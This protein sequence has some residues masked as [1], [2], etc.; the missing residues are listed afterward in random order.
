MGLIYYINLYQIYR[1]IEIEIII[2]YIYFIIMDAIEITIKINNKDY[3]VLSTF[4]KKDLNDWI[5]KLFKTGYNIHF[6]S[7]DTI[8]QHIKNSEVVGCIN[9]MKDEIKEK[10][11]NSELNNT[12]TKLIGIS[13]NSYK[14][15]NFGENVLEEFFS[16]KYGDIKFERKSG[17][18][19][20]GDAW[21]HSDDGT[22]IM[23]ESKNYA[24]TVNKDEFS[25][26]KADMITHHIKYAILVSFNSSIQGM[27]EMDFITFSHHSDIYSIITI[28][29]L[30]MDINRLDLGIQILKKL[31]IHNKK[32]SNDM[33]VLSDINSS[34][35][36]LDSIIMKNYSLRDKFYM[37][38]KVMQNA[39]SEFHIMMRDYQYDIEK[40]IKDIICKVKNIKIEES[41]NYDNIMEVY[42]ESKMLPT[43]VR[44]IDICM[45]KKWKLIQDEDSNMWHIVYIEN[46]IGIMKIQ[47]KKVNIYIND[48]DL[49]LVLNLG[50]EKANKENLDFI[51]KL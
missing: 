30:A 7:N 49:T 43:I 47:A 34:L 44:I 48:N 39:L 21:L 20:S 42:K 45:I 9:M 28:S 26:L 29:N 18:A 31:I 8:Q 32:E 50:K 3:P 41:I 1:K 51:K 10:L 38:E 27:K 17:T 35:V 40:K 33:H 23:L 14:K 6:P 13:S 37:T 24:T 12:L 5:I 19:H 15:G 11:D 25:K 22:I 36:E 16:G 4:K 2:N 46:E